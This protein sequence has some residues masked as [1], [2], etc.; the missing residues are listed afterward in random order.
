VYLH[1]CQFDA[2]LP[3]SCDVISTHFVSNSKSSVVFYRYV[4]RY[5]YMF[6]RIAI[7]RFV[8]KTE[9]LTI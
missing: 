4:S 7:V 9:Q 3:F 5:K 8:E 6:R 2:D 1:Y